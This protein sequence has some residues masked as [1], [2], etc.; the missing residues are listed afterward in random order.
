MFCGKMLKT[1]VNTL[2]ENFEKA[3][4]KKIILESKV[5]RG[6]IGGVVAKVGNLLIDSSIRNQLHQLAE[7]LRKE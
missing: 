5:D 4:E 6:L 3:L 7:T 1:I 2:K